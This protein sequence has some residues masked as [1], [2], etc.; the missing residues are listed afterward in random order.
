MTTV[1]IC[2]GAFQTVESTRQIPREVNSLDEEA[3]HDLKLL[4]EVNS[5][6]TIRIGVASCICHNALISS[7]CH[8][9]RCILSPQRAQPAPSAF[10][11]TTRATRN[12]QQQLPSRQQAKGNPVYSYGLVPLQCSRPGT[13]STLWNITDSKL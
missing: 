2:T 13:Q 12:T 3:D 10:L 11:A 1:R 7:V 5:A 6:P 9:G 8:A 4:S